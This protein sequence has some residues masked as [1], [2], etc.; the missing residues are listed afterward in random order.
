[1]WAPAVTTALDAVADGFPRPARGPWDAV[2]ATPDL[3]PGSIRRTTSIDMC[4]TDG[5]DGRLTAEIRGRDLRRRVGADGATVD[6][7][8]DEVRVAAVIEEWTGRLISIDGDEHP[9]LPALIGSSIRRGYGR[10]LAGAMADDLAARTLLASILEDLGGAL[11]VSGYAPLN[12][13]LLGMA[14]AEGAERA[15]AQ[16]DICAGWATGAPLVE[17][18][19]A[20]GDNAVPVGPAAPPLTASDGWHEM[21]VPELETVTRIR[22]LDVGWPPGEG[23]GGPA[24]SGGPVS[25]RA[26]FRDAYQGDDGPMIMHEYVVHAEVGGADPVIERVVVEPRVLP[27]SECPSA[28]ASSSGVV[29]TRVGDLPAR[30]RADLVGPSTCTHL[31]S[32]LRSL[33]DVRPLLE[34]LDR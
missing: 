30:V 16:Q 12:R 6:E 21:I 31:N 29:G 10:A 11:L 5:F 8:L 26:H 2:G 4:R 25:V 18:L 17:R 1:M 7:V 19:R 27:W 3:V 22:S 13:G 15:A 34:A 24:G 23:S 20:T 32:T 28:A 9:A 14:P 33:A